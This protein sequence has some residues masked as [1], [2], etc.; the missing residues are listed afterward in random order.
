LPLHEALSIIRHGADTVDPPGKDVEPALKL[1]IGDMVKLSLQRKTLFDG[2]QK[3]L[4]VTAFAV[5]STSADPNKI[6]VLDKTGRAK[7][8][9]SRDEFRAKM[10]KL[11]RKQRR[12]DCYESVRY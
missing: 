9:V 11:E 1:K 7:Y 4:L 8:T 5:V 6:A 3:R 12:E 10:Q 2:S